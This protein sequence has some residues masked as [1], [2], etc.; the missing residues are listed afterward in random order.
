MVAC[1]SIHSLL[2][3]F[4]ATKRTLEEKQPKKAHSKNMLEAIDYSSC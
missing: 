3:T 2:R 4:F 1:N